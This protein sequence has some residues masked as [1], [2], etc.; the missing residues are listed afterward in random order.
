MSLSN[1]FENRVAG[2]LVHPT[3]LPDSESC[4]GNERQNSFG[5]L[6]REAFNFVDFMAAAGLKVWQVL[7]LVPTEDNLSPYQSYS[8]HAGNPDLISFDDL[9]KRGWIDSG[10]LQL[11]EKNRQGLAE[12]RWKCAHS[13]YQYIN[14]DG[15]GE[16]RQQFEEFCAA[17][18]SWLDDFALFSALRKKFNGSSWVDWPGELRKR[19]SAALDQQRSELQDEINSVRF[20]QF[21]FFSQWLD[22]KHYANQKGIAVLGDIPIF[23]GH[24]S[25]DV[26][27]EPHYFSLDDN[28]NPLTV[29]GVPPDAFSES[30]QRWGNPHYRWDVMEKDGFQWWLKRFG[31]Q[32][33]LF[34]LIR[35]DHFL[36][37]HSVYEIPGDKPDA[38]EGKWINTPGDALLQATFSRYPDLKLVAENL[39]KIPPELED[40]RLKFNLPGML[41]LH[42]A[43]ESDDNPLQLHHHTEHNIVYTGTHDNNTT[44]GWFNELG[45][46]E[47]KRFDDYD[48]QADDQMP[49]YLMD[50]ALASVARVAIIPMQDFLALG[51]DSRMNMPGTPDKNWRW[52]FSWE[53]V[54][55]SLAGAIKQRLEKYNRLAQAN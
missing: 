29:A 6:G 53:Q 9:V 18:K 12:L 15:G 46:E 20:E 28:G 24:N 23:V 27:A 47:R 54:D 13:F 42:F 4:W 33:K 21:A 2:I 17:E 41:V 34:D 19:E 10:C 38:R 36:G 14:S 45:D 16:T 1:V 43:F 3:S 50:M 11:P 48:F 40:L 25:A 30:G 55:V 8:V 5:T 32:K 49:W 37:F 26:W 52:R 44:A 7:P 35:I 51:S 31:S 39:G 22:L